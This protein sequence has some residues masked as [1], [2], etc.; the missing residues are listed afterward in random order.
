MYN[1]Y[2][3]VAIIV[4]YS[5][6][7]RLVKEVIEACIEENVSQIVLV[8]NGSSLESKLIYEDLVETR[9][10]IFLISLDFNTGSSG[11]FKTGLEYVLNNITTDFVWLLDD[12][13][14]PQKGALNSLFHA[15]SS[16][17]GE[18]SKEDDVVLYSYR[19]DSKILDRNAV[20][21]GF[22]KRYRS[23]E[24]MGFNILNSLKTKFK[25][26]SEV[27]NFPLV[28]VYFG[29][30]GGS[31]FSL[32]VLS[33]LGL[34]NENFFV[35][36]D[37]HEYTLRLNNL[38]IDQFLVY[39]SKILDIDYSFDETG[40]F[41]KKLLDF[42][43]YFTI[44]NHVYLNQFYITNKFCYSINKY[45]TLLFLFLSSFRYGF[46]YKFIKKR[47]KLIFKAINEGEKQNLG[48]DFNP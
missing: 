19:G 38:N 15:K 10:N 4:T 25:E 29:P 7:H 21:N 5:N 1:S 14:V 6:R 13:N 36:A 3:T 11:G 23:N 30:Y 9:N 20:Y 8:D 22:I 40:F 31:F 24:F 45:L 34:P 37:D 32:K 43:V 17:L 26:K 39:N 48:K 44:R 2:S 16:I 33:K 41:G 46:D 35:Y 18:C 27:V 28:R 12:D 47:F 42:K